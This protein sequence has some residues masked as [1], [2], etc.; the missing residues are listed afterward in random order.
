MASHEKGME[1]EKD[2]LKARRFFKVDILSL[3]S[4]VHYLALNE[5][6]PEV[7]GYQ[8]LLHTDN[9]PLETTWTITDYCKNNQMIA[10][11]TGPCALAG[12]A[13]SYNLV[14]ERK[15][16]LIVKD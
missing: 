3:L 4:H 2:F 8:F 9:I 11:G 13:I 7:D 15:Y 5:A 12:A 16:T 6:W 10:E 1:N 14:D